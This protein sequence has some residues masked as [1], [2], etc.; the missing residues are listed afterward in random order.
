MTIH[1]SNITRSIASARVGEEI[2]IRIRDELGKHDVITVDLI[3]VITITTYCAKQIFGQLYKDLG[4]SEALRR[5]RMINASADV[6][7]AIR[8]GIDASLSK[9]DGY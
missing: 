3:D 6:K 4:V 1:I 2:L 5:M 8:L 9:M 7:T